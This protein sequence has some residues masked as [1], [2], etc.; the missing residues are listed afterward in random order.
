VEVN[1]CQD[2]RLKV[3]AAVH[4]L[5]D[6]INYN[7]QVRQLFTSLRFNLRTLHGNPREVDMFNPSDH[8]F[9][10]PD[11]ILTNCSCS[12]SW[13]CAIRNLQ[14][15]LMTNRSSCMR[16]SRLGLGFPWLHR[17]S[18]IQL[19]SRGLLQQRKTSINDSFK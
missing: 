2:E 12:L 8:Q 13:K 7:R 3:A 6:R 14:I 18:M 11:S 16:R 9:I 19:I 10:I 1:F 5:A 15:I 17:A 4:E